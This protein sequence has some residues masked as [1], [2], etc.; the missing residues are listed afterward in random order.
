M[1]VSKTFLS[2]KDSVGNIDPFASLNV[3]PYSRFLIY[4]TKRKSRF[5]KN[6]KFYRCAIGML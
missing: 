3:V 2:L 4:V 5:P 1:N 6:S